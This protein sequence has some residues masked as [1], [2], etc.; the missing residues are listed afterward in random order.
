MRQAVHG[1]ISS[2]S[3]GACYIRPIIYRGYDSL[4]V[5]PLPC[6]VDVAIMVWEW[7]AYFTK[8]AIEEYKAIYMADS[9]Y[10]DVSKKINDFY[11]SQ[12][13]PSA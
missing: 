13:N 6:P 9:G 2:N 8:E 4:G 3:L 11:E 12:K 5:N 1:V 10:R 7:G